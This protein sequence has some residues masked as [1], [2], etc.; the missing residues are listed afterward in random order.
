MSLLLETTK[1]ADKLTISF[2]I[3]NLGAEEIERI[4]AFIETEL[5]ARKSKLTQAR[6]DEIAEEMTA[7]WWHK[8]KAGIDRMVAENG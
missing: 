3:G 7:S 2:P 1:T 8:N 4:L 5:I 6:A